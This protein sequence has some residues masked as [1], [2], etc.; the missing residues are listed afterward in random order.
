MTDDVSQTTAPDDLM[1][2]VK[3]FIY[4]VAANEFTED[5]GIFVCAEW[6]SLCSAAGEPMRMPGSIFRERNP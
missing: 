2:C 6:H 5:Q 4:W 3:D 1:K